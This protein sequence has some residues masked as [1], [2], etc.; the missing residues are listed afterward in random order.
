MDGASTE[1]SPEA[2]E[3]EGRLAEAV[4][5]YEARNRACPDGRIEQH[6]VRLR[7]A[8]FAHQPPAQRAPWPTDTAEVPAPDPRIGLPVVGPRELSSGLVRSA[9]AKHG[10]LYVRGLFDS[11]QVRRMRNATECAIAARAAAMQGAP[12]ERTATWYDELEDVP[13][14][15]ARSF[16]S[17]D[18]S[19]VAGDSPRGFFLLLETFREIGIDRHVAGFFGERPAISFEK[20]TLRR[21]PPGSG[22]SWHQ[23][24]AFLGE[25]I[26][27]LNVWVSLSRCGRRSPGIEI[28]QRRIERLLP[29][30]GYF[31]WDVAPATVAKEF[32]GLRPTAPEFEP[33]DGLLFDHL[34]LHRTSSLPGMTETRYAIESWFFAPSAYPTSMTGLYV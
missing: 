6:L 16:V 24:G 11:E 8:A 9:I 26:R 1:A 33:G 34:C 3:R 13:N 30:G 23:D 28:V 12:R 29:T 14:G 20:C 4:S 15:G 7:R 31:D 18:G 5:A 2:L 17:V 32:P 22:S 21:T 27:S 19:V 25:N 10:S